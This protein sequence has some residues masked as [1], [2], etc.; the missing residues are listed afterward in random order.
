MADFNVTAL[1]R[2]WSG[3]V[4]TMTPEQ[5]CA[6]AI[7]EALEEAE[8]VGKAAC[9]HDCCHGAE[10]CEVARAIAALRRKE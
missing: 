8:R 3:Y 5:M 6:A 9:C 2:K 7:S 10:N 4:A 1:A